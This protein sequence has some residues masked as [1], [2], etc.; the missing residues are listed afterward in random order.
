MK[1][2]RLK[3]IRFKTEQG[4]SVYIPLFCTN[5]VL[6]GNSNTGKSYIYN[7]LKQLATDGKLNFECICFD[8]D[9]CTALRNTFRHP[10]DGLI[11][12]E[13]FDILRIKF[14]ELVDWLNNQ[15]HQVLLIG[16]NLNGVMTYIWYLFEIVN[17]GKMLG[18]KPALSKTEYY[19]GGYTK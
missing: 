10:F 17:K 5:T 9:D 2:S 19:E 11:V 12:L 6:L 1:R 14:P 13:D 4:Y 16:R 8:P 15:D 3:E 18:V 7:S